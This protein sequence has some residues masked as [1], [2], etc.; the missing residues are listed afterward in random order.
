MALAPSIW[1][2]SSG[3]S[4][5]LG[6][7]SS[8]KI[9]KKNFEFRKKPH[10][11]LVT[12]AEVTL[13]SKFHPFW[14]PVA[15]ESKLRRKFLGR[16]DISASIIGYI[17]RNRTYPVQGRTCPPGSFNSNVCSLFWSYLANLV[18]N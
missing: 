11:K 5:N 18:S 17:R 2:I 13:V 12:C 10:W 3:F 14:C 8:S 7:L 6:S 16:S 15:Q 4:Q 9:G 1:S